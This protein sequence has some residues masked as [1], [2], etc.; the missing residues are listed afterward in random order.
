M[1]GQLESPLNR[2]AESPRHMGVQ[3]TP[4]QPELSCS[5]TWWLEVPSPSCPQHPELPPWPLSSSPVLSSCQ[6]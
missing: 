6:T 1:G 2:Q 4:L 5:D 3:C